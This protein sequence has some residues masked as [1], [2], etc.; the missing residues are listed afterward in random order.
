MTRT[1]AVHVSTIC[2]ATLPSTRLSIAPCPL[3]PI[4]MRSV[5]L[6]ALRITGTG[7]PSITWVVI[8]RSG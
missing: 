3:C 8:F 4:T 2:F 6:V 5:P 1:G 7:R